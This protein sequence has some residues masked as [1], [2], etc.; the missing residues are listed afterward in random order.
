[1]TEEQ[2]AGEVTRLLAAR[3]SLRWHRCRDS[4]FCRGPRGW[5]DLAVIGSGLV[6]RELK[7]DDTRT[8]LYQAAYGDALMEAGVSW[9]VWRPA[10]LESGR[11]ER[12]L[13]GLC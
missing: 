8:R 6:V 4:R 2:L 10:D 7:G 11:I 12:E 9:S 3:P 5:P 1:M 13:D